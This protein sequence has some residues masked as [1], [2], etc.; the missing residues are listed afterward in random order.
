M[1]TRTA[2]VALLAPSAAALSVVDTH[3]HNA[4]LTL[5][6]DSFYTFP[7]SFPDLAS[8]WFMPD[9][10]AEVA[11][12]TAAVSVDRVVLMELEKVN[13]TFD[14]GRA[15]AA[16]YQATADACRADPDS[17][18]G[19][20]VAGFVASAPLE[21]D[22]DAV[23]AYLADL[24]ASF[25]QLVG[26]REGLWLSDAS[27]FADA[28]FRA[29]LATLAQ[30]DLAFDLLVEK[31]QLQDTAALAAAVPSVRMNVNHL[32]YPNISDTDP[33]H[34]ASW[35]ADVQAL[36]EQPN[37]FLKLSGLPQCYGQPGWSADAFTPFIQ[38][39]LDAF[40]AQRVNF[41]G[42]WFVLVNDEWQGDY[43]GMV[44]AVLQSLS[45]LGVSQSDLEWIFAKTAEQIYGL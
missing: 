23:R 12:V 35:A 34:F 11:D 26:I 32:G 31:E 33:D 17:C 7:T 30:F 21:Q 43:S 19:T 4:N 16:F 29:G 36:A 37:V 28:G 15:E 6:G 1:R 3:V 39:V 45:D 41:A 40:G 9:F 44:D 27:F 5:M 8:S 42:N 10:A 25:P 2:L 18:G 14:A 22:T 24:Q 38:T 20:Q 13:N